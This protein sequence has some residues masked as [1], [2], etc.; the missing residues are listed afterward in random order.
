MMKQRW[1]L[2][3]NLLRPIPGDPW[4]V[5]QHHWN[6]G[7]KENHSWTPVCKQPV[8][9]PAPSVFSQATPYVRW[10]DRKM[11]IWWIDDDINTDFYYSF[12]PIVILYFHFTFI[13]LQQ[14]WGLETHSD[15]GS[16]RTSVTLQ[17]LQ[18]TLNGN[19][20]RLPWCCTYTN[21]RA[22][23]GSATQYPHIDRWF[24]RRSVDW[25][26]VRAGCGIWLYQFLIIAYRFTLLM[27][28]YIHSW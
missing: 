13:Y 7:A 4:G 23:N 8:K 2:D 1:G 28:G 25:I 27:S 24:R 21:N 9:R 22:L 6:T 11:V 15:R 5:E 18:K 16:S 17:A 12:F 26:R 14:Y 20:S 10:Y 3:R 19:W